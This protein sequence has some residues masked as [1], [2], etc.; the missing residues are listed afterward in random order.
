M[1]VWTQ[2]IE[3]TEHASLVA[4]KMSEPPWVYT[5]CLVVL[6]IPRAMSTSSRTISTRYFSILT[7]CQ[8][9]FIIVICYLS[10]CTTS[11]SSCTRVLGTASVVLHTYEHCGESSKFETRMLP[12]H[13]TCF[14]RSQ[15]TFLSIRAGPIMETSTAPALSEIF[16]FQS[17]SQWAHSIFVVRSYLCPT[18]VLAWQ[19]L[20]RFLALSGVPVSQCI[21]IRVC[22]QCTTD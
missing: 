20:V 19:S 17:Y 4:L 3:C 7:R 22:S 2:T 21:A 18:Q 11:S 9:Y 12:G 6:W 15:I 14:S 10:T 16:L 5:S 8:T 13:R 1:C